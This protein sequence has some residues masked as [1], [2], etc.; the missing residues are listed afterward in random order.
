MANTPHGR[1]LDRAGRDEREWSGHHDDQAEARVD[2]DR[3]G[4]PGATCGGKRWVYALIPD[5]AIAEN[6][7]LDGITSRYGVDLA[8]IAGLSPES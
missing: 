2:L 8:R 5:D 3:Q 4:E 6:M 7:T 1:C